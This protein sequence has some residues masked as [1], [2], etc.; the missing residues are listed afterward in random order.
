MAILPAIS[1]SGLT[2][3]GSLFQGIERKTAAK[4]SFL[5]SIPAI[6]GAVVVQGKDL[7]E[8]SIEGIGM[9][10]LVVGTLVSALCGYI[11]VRWMLKIIQRGSLKGFS[12]YV[13]IIGAGILLAQFLGR[14]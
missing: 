4:F 1:R 8:G 6:M 12:V 14:F 10:S 2:I 9:S 3:A 5:L 11:A 7:F 13:W